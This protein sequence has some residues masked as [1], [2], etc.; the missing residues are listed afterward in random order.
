M[1]KMKTIK[2]EEQDKKDG[3]PCRIETPDGYIKIKIKIKMKTI[4]EEEQ[5]KKDGS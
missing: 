3:S 1:I 5:D 2:E 4:K